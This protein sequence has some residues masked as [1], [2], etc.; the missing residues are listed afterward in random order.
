MQPDTVLNL[1]K[2]ATETYGILQTSENF[3]TI[4]HELSISFW[5]A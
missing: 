5:V 2:I 3:S 4:L 1:E